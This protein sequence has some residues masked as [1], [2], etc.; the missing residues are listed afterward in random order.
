LTPTDRATLEC[1]VVSPGL[2]AAVET[3]VTLLLAAVLPAAAGAIGTEPQLDAL[4]PW[5]RAW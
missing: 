2:A 3:Q 4:G 1:L 5:S